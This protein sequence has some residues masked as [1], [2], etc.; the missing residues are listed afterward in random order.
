MH[1]LDWDATAERY[2]ALIPHVGRRD[3]LNTLM[4]ELIA[5]LHVGHNRVGGGDVEH[6]PNPGRRT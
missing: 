6:G 4:V 5:E 3:D 1:G 2:R